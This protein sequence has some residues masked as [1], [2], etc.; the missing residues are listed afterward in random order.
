M[1]KTD[2]W[3][4]LP[5]VA[6][7]GFLPIQPGPAW[8]LMYGRWEYCEA[9]Y[10]RVE[11]ARMDE[12]IERFQTTPPPAVPPTAREIFESIAAETAKW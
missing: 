5:I 2:T 11:K 4:P 3:R 10:K 9:C 8:I 6:T 7:V 1:S 12:A